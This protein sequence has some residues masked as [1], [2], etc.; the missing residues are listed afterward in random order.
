MESI[1]DRHR[2]IL[3]NSMGYLML[4]QRESKVRQT[5]LDTGS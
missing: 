2:T 5:A 3:N 1:L 4:S